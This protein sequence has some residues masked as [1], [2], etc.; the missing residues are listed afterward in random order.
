MSYS[1]YSINTEEMQEILTETFEKIAERVA[2]KKTI[3]PKLEN[4]LTEKQFD[5][6]SECG[7]YV[8]IGKNLRVVG[9]NF[10][11]NRL[12]PVCN[13]RNSAQK[14]AKMYQM[15]Q[16]A[17][18]DLDPCFAFLTLTVKNISGDN[19]ASEI[20]KLMKSIDRLHKR[21]IFKENVYGYFRSLEV[22]YN[23]RSKTFHPHYHYILLLPQSYKSDFIS[24]FEWRTTWEQCARLDYVSQVDIRLI[25]EDNIA[26][27]VAEVAKYAVK[28]SSV[29]EQDKKVL[30]YLTAAI[31]GRRLISF[32]GVLKDYA[33][34]NDKNFKSY[35]M[36]DGYEIFVYQLNGKYERGQ[37]FE[38]IPLFEA[39][40]TLE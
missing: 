35:D 32:G 33:K 3:Q 16:A 40:Q 38:N 5:K 1:D 2:F 24:T 28:I 20:S 15:A 11:R 29:I 12:C 17:R 21:K 39:W 14:W 4:V 8:A 22:T 18:A 26:D 6:F 37:E 13:R 30:K 34:E 7:K 25:E 27:A 23:S 10:C 31:R 36:S 9:G 19:L